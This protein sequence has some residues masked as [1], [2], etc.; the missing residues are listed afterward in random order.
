MATCSLDVPLVSV[1]DL[2]RDTNDKSTSRWFYD[3]TDRDKIATTAIPE[4]DQ[5]LVR[6]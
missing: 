1:W 5:N 6:C 2:G 3:F 4:M